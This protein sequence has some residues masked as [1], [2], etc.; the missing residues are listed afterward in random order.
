[1]GLQRGGTAT[2]P[3]DIPAWMTPRRAHGAHTGERPY[4]LAWWGCAALGT[5]PVLLF[6]AMVTVPEAGASL[7]PQG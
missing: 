6:P 7:T 3:G 5:L 2:A 4:S 1:M